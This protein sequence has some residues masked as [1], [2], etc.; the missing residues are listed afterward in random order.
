MGFSSIFKKLKSKHELLRAAAA[1]SNDPNKKV[2]FCGYL[3]SR[4][5]TARK[6]LVRELDATAVGVHEWK[7]L[8]ELPDTNQVSGVPI[9]KNHFKRF[10]DNDPTKFIYQLFRKHEG[11]AKLLVGHWVLKEEPVY[12]Q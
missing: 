10:F 4:S 12:Q 9:S 3:T 7:L 1:H 2:F 8:S 11:E 6:Q 5:L